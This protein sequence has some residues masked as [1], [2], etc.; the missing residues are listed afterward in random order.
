MKALPRRPGLYVGLV[1]LVVLVVITVIVVSSRSPGRRVVTVPSSIVSNCSRPVDGD[2]NRFLSSVPNG[3]TVRFARNGCYRQADSLWLRDRSRIV[4]DGNNAI[5]AFDTTTHLTTYYR[6]N[7]RILRGS[8]I[9]L[10]HMTVRGACKPQQCG[11]GSV[12]P[13][14]DGYGQH[15][16][17]LESTA[18]PTVEHV[19]IMDVLSDGIEAE[20]TLN[21]KCCW[22]GRPTSDLVVRD[23]HIERAGRQLIGLTDVDRGL[24]EGNLIENGPEIGVDI[25]VDVPGFLG[26]DLR[27]TNNRFDN[28][29]ANIISNGGLGGSPDVANI[30]IE[31]NTM[32]SRSKA[33]AGGIYLRAPG[34]MPQSYRSGFTIS[35]NAFKLIGPMVQAE[36]IRNLTIQSNT[37]DFREAGCGALGAVELRDSHAVVVAGNTFRGYARPVYA[38]RASTQIISRP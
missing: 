31:R 23:S 18:R 28:I 20:G 37:T 10:E 11:N 38:D 22:S 7:W 4:L 25:E 16:I 13:A 5:F 9:T 27:I 14:R 33:C 12:P 32:T 8:D 29:H 36:A 2:I 30:S 21:P 15:G 3:S 17:S 26:R 24:I 35:G 19:H 34:P 1:V 6:S